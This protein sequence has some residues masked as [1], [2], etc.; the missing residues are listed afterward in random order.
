MKFPSNKKYIN[1]SKGYGNNKIKVVTAIFLGLQIEDKCTLNI[2]HKMAVHCY[3]HNS[4][5]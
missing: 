5:K 1:L 4:P 3:P 2:T